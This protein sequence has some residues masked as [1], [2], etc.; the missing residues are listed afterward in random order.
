MA[1][2]QC[3]RK[4]RILGLLDSCTYSNKLAIAQ[5]LETRSEGRQRIA[6]ISRVQYSR[7]SH[8]AGAVHTVVEGCYVHPIGHLAHPHAVI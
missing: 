3:K 5:R 8:F 7:M 6:R 2:Q 1:P 4:V